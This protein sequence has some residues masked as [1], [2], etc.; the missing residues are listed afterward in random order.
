MDREKKQPPVLPEEPLPK[1]PGV[2]EPIIAAGE[3]AAQG[4]DGIVTDPQGSYTGTPIDGGVPVQDAD[5][6]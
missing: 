5:D 3:M 6:L 4:T 2:V 1:K